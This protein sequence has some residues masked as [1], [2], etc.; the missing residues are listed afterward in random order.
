MSTE[1]QMQKLQWLIRSVADYGNSLEAETV[2][3]STF[4][5]AA[6]A[7]EGV[8]RID[9][10][11]YL[12]HPLAVAAI[13]AEWHAPVQ[14]VAIGLLHDLVNPLY[15]RE[16]SSKEVPLEKLHTEL[17]PDISNLLDVVVRLNNFIRHVEG[18]DFYNQD[19]TNDFWQ[20][21]A[22]YL[23]QAS[24][25]VL[26]KIADRLHN[27]QSCAA[28]IPSYQAQMADAGLHL[29]VPLL[30]RLGMGKVRR[31][32]EDL[33]FQINDP[34]S[35]QMLQQR[36][37]APHFQE[38]IALVGEELQQ[39]LS[40][41]L[42]GS[43]IIWRPASL[44]SIWQDFKPGRWSQHDFS[45]LRMVDVGSFIILMQE[46]IECY[47]AL[48]L[49]HKRY[50]PVEG[51]VR[52]QIANRRDN[53]YQSLNTQ[54]K[55]FSGNLL[56][57][58]IRT[59]TMDMIA[60][61]GITA[62][63]R[64]I[65]EE[66][67]PQLLVHGKPADREIQVFTPKGEMRPLPPGATPI[68]F[69]YSIHTDVGHQCVDVLVNGVRGDLY[70]PLQVD[71]RVEIIRGGPECG[72]KLEW[73]SHVKTTQ[74]MSRIRHWLSIHRRD[75]MVERGRALLNR[76]LQKLGL[77][78]SDSSVSQV[79]SRLAQRERLRDADELL[80]ALGVERNQ[81][82]K[83][84]ASLK[85][86]RLKSVRTPYYGEPHMSV[87]V[88]S[89]EYE[90]LP[91]TFARCC[92]PISGDDIVGYVRNDNII[93]IHKRECR[94]LSEKMQLIQV[95]WKTMKTDPDWVILIEALNRPGLARDVSDIITLA[96]IDML[97]FYAAKRPDGVMADVRVYLG[98]TTRSQRERLQK[99][100]E[101]VSS[102]NTVELIQ[103]S[104]LAPPS[105]LI[106]APKLANAT[107]QVIVATSDTSGELRYP[108]PYSSGIA[109][110][111]RFYGREIERERV[112]GFLHN[113]TQNV[114]ILL[115][116]QRRIGKTSFV[117]RLKEHAAGLFL[118]IYID[119]QGLK[120]ASTAMFLHRLMVRISQA[121]KENAVEAPQEITAPALNRLR[122][123]P[124]AYFDNF[125]NYVQEIA[126][127]YPFVLI[128]DEFQCL[129]S[130]REEGANR[131][132]IFN[133]LRSH[134]QHGQGIHLIFSGGG[135]L[136]YLKDQSDI[137]SLFN[138]A[139][140]ENLGC[141]D[142]KDAHQLIKDGLS[143]VGSVTDNAITQLLYYTAGHPYYL[144]L[145]CSMLHD[146]AQ[147]QR[148]VITAD[149]VAQRI[150]LWLET[151]DT[152]RFQH[153]WEGHDLAHTLRNKL[154]L[155]AV[156]QLGH[157]T[158]IVEYD[159]LVRAIGSMVSEYDLVQSLNDL[160]E[161]G[162][163]EHH[164]QA[165]YSIKVNLFARWLHQHY[166]LNM[167]LKEAL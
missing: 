90:Q 56:R 158:H 34:L 23:A 113:K 98:K 67:I 60:E 89:S 165:S 28:L 44:Y 47:H 4:E 30:G 2:L 43:K 142:S 120:D 20:G 125:M 11:P 54:I 102:V 112:L 45:S 40:R 42:P 73:L 86:M 137:A 123:D 58:A 71:D 84:V 143:K 10:Q 138:I 136:S 69:A 119:L 128:L 59:V 1:Q 160:S 18:S 122:K 139:H 126:R 159:H 153:F 83:V 148:S 163:L 85:S 16:H 24:D 52:D 147:E 135:L 36:C 104:L 62:R 66:F 151:A 5:I 116:G 166:S 144:Q 70:Q 115:W 41:L 129:N 81:P 157:T 29:Q 149:I 99:A 27:L 132:A 152:S 51:Q 35:Y 49:L 32:V 134:S 164:Y 6:K 64:G 101:G 26:V 80:V 53:G 65:N 106:E 37:S 72:P 48:G 167:A 74:A 162:V 3:T 75:E 146:H 39:A 117:L 124:L 31:Q 55:H 131:S 145:L 33:C 25:A 77:D 13:L 110:G 95:K 94:Q 107:H 105:T 61:N 88:L 21:I 155:V 50:H 127:L 38:E 97:T 68:D 111:S 12:N 150:R 133:R 109:R 103:A 9:G 130:L 79:L 141:L 108:N 91:R 22:T 78:T 76:E 156:A 15:S 93:A 140:A 118:P 154:I 100:L 92:V 87:Q 96:A 121:L 114:A 161:L 8:K 57:V 63:W 17:G 46:E 82:S 14:V 19:D 7:H